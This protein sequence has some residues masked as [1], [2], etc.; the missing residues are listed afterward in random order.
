MAVPNRHPSLRRLFWP[1]LLGATALGIAVALAVSHSLDNQRPSAASHSPE[2]PGARSAPAPPEPAPSEVRAVEPPLPSERESAEPPA[3]RA[4]PPAVGLDEALAFLP[5]VYPAGQW[6]PRGL[7]QQDCWFTTAD[8]VRL[9]AWLFPHRRPRAVVLYAHG[10]GGNLSYH[11]PLMAW[12]RDRLEVSILIFDYRG[13]GRSTGTPTV[14]GILLDA[15]AARDELARLAGTKP[16]RVVLWGRS[17]G[18]AVAVDLAA[19]D[20]ARGLI[21]ESSFTSYREVAAIHYPPAIV[22]AAV[23]ERLAPID[24]IGQ[25]R[26][27]V[28]VAH[29]TADEVVPYRMGRALFER[30]NEPKQFFRLAGG[31]HETLPPRFYAIAA[32]FLAEVP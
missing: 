20:G 27:P 24:L 12:L 17:L 1:A 2:P 31:G 4:P 19:R 23:P 6:Q 26:G 10:N 3:V 22:Q 5:L 32:A 15:R 29:G 7:G 8:G 9:H 14:D 16:E 30:A 13:F 11:G 28:L 21:V 18:G 25:Y